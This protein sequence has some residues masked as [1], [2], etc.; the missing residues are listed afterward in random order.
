MKRIR[1]IISRNKLYAVLATFIILINLA[2]FVGRQAE[3]AEKQQ[4]A[5][6][7]QVPQEKVEEEKTLYD[8]EDVEARR[9]K[10][11]E[12]AKKDPKLYFFLGI[13]N[14][15][16]L[17]VI[18]VGI[19]FDGYFIGR[20]LRKKPLNI[21]TNKP[22]PP[23]WT[24]A[25][26]VR[27]TL[28]F[29]SCGYVFVILQ[30]FFAKAVPILDNEN[31]RMILD[32]AMVNIVG[33]S[34]ILYFIVKK[35]NQDISALGLTTKGLTKNIFYAIVAYIALVPVLL[36]IMALTFFVV[37]FIQYKPPVQPI[38][39]VFLKEEEPTV[40]WASA[41]FAAVFGPIAEEIFFRGFVYSTIKKSFGIF[42]AMIV[43]SAVFSLL[44]THIVGFVPIMILGLLLAYLY[45]KT[46]SLVS[47]MSVH[48]AH[49]LAMVVLVFLA[50]GIGA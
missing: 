39:E 2:V 47:C 25:D 20:W 40:L 48:I 3:K 16:I 43:T 9:D 15:F 45:E 41:I 50:R 19:L 12:L 5:A 46:G 6:G 21:A 1:D 8:E 7:E 10:I 23:R 28:I 24:I 27:V 4:E 49:N 29:L 44:H 36:A 42:W 35:Y 34:V 32:T 22:E 26:I 38:V 37:K 30:A 13:L 14:L 11:E 18:F 17:F 31:F 33:I